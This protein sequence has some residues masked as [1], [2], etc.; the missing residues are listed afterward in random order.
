VTFVQQLLMCVPQ[1][2]GLAK[3]DGTQQQQD[4]QDGWPYSAIGGF[5]AAAALGLKHLFCA[6]S[7]TSRA[8][9]RNRGKGW[10]M[11]GFR[12]GC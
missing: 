10:L 11:Q 12:R 9:A 1:G 8:A 3:H 2:Q 5:T 7:S 6:I 4:D